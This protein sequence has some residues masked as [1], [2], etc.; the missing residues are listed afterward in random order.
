MAT[1]KKTPAKKAPAK[2]VV[3]KKAAL[4]K[5]EHQMFDMPREVS[6]WIE[7]ANS[8]INHLKGKIERLERENKELKAYRKFAEGRILNVSAE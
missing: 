7:R 1:A 4:K 6:E 2:K 3:A 8:T 5:Q